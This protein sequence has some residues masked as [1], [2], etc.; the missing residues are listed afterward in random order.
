MQAGHELVA[1]SEAWQPGRL[2]VPQGG[3]SAG[4]H[5]RSLHTTSARFGG[6]RLALGALVDYRGLGGAVCREAHLLGKPFTH[7]RATLRALPGTSASEVGRRGGGVTLGL[8]TR[9]TCGGVC[10]ELVCG[11][12]R[13][14]RGHEL[15]RRQE[16]LA[17]LW[18]QHL[19]VRGIPRRKPAHLLAHARR[20]RL[21]RAGADGRK[22]CAC[23]VVPAPHLRVDGR[24][25][26]QRHHLRYPVQAPDCGAWLDGIQPLG[27]FRGWL[28]AARL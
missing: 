23:L 25:H 1:G 14:R 6:L 24:T 19:S 26:C 28:S 9:T 15:L 4:C 16:A 22:L 21:Q 5:S 20:E 3:C 7:L 12:H 10:K 11:R 18:Q 17:M 8:A 13:A 27:G 2:A